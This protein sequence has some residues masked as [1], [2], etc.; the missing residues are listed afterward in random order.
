[1]SDVFALLTSLPVSFVEFESFEIDIIS[2]YSSFPH[3]DGT[4]EFFCVVM[5]LSSSL[6]SSSRVILQHNT[7]EI[8]RI[9]FSIL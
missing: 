6:A 7:R 4:V 3:C 5:M 9:F 8:F 1:M 2:S